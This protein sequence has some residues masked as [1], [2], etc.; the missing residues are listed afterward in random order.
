MRSSHVAPDSGAKFPITEFPRVG[1]LK[2]LVRSPMIE[3]GEYSYYDDPEGPECFEEK[4]VLYHYDFIGDRL[5]I[6]R[7]CALATG[8]QFVMNGA[9][10]ALD[11]FSTF[12][13]GIFPGA[14]REGFDAA[15]Y[16]TGHRGDTIVGNDVWIG[17][18]ATILPG[19]RIGDGAIIAAKSVVAK[20]V[21]PYAVVAGNPA[22]VVRMRFPAGVVER[23]LAI[24]WWRW[25]I[26]KV[27]RN[28]AAITGADLEA[29]EDAL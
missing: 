16:A 20:D 4:C 26:D 5:V 8:V 15:A 18:E 12:P 22:R 6:G 21:P 13:F 19:V 25:P 23:L 14:W 9:N 17:M 1:F 24:A 27:T 11:G 10:H 3:I 28:I 7:F 29:L 2:N